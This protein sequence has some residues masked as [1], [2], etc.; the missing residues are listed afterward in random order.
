MLRTGRIVPLVILNSLPAQ[1]TDRVP[2]PRGPVGKLRRCRQT[3]NH[4][5]IRGFLKNHEVRRGRNDRLGQCLLSTVSPKADVVA[6][7]LQRHSAPPAGTTT[8]YGSPNKTS[9]P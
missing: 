9:R 4:S 8:K 6:Q 1:K 5:R 3:L 7:Y 2:A